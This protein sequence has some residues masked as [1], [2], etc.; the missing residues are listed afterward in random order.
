[1][2]QPKGHLKKKFSPKGKKIDITKSGA[3][4]KEPLG[5]RWTEDN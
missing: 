5:Y 2:F 3:R 4:H 1:M